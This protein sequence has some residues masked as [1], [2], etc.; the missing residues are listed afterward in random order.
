M[1]WN[2]TENSERQ[3]LVSSILRNV[4]GAASYDASNLLDNLIRNLGMPRNLSAVGIT[5]KHFQKIA[6][7]AMFT[8]WVPHN[9]R[10]I[11]GPPEI[12]QILQLA[13]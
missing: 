2:K 7:Q 5:H 8:P 12:I 3:Q 13:A 4:E 1:R 11:M 9:P 10:P 6:E